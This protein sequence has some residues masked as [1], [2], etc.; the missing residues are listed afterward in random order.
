MT[1]DFDFKALRALKFNA[2]KKQYF[3]NAVLNKAKGGLVLT[4]FD[5][6]AEKKTCA[7]VPFNKYKDAE[8]AFK[9]WKA[10]KDTNLKKSANKVALVKVST[11][12]GEEGTVEVVLDIVKGFK[13]PKKIEAAARPLFDL[14]EKGLKVTGTTEEEEN[15]STADLD[16][17]SIAVQIKEL[18]LGITGIL[19]EELPKAIVPNIKAKKV[20]QKDADITNDL[21]TK[22][23]EL[24]AVY[25]T[26]GSDIQ[27]KIGKHYDSIMNQV[28]K[29]EKVK[30][31]LNNLLGIS[32]GNK[33]V[34]KEDTNDS[35]EVKQ[36]KKLL[37]YATKETDAIWA[38][39][40]KTKDE[41]SKASSQAIKG[42]D[43]LLK[44]LFN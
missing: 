21:F 2:Y 37:A 3:K 17:K 31:A 6:G 18:V 36:L 12:K 43:Q 7:F 26:A 23:D 19:K 14:V 32:E 30:A 4:I 38:S 29:L 44:A 16:S 1:E 35:E 8:N 11:Q 27:Q 28:P 5:I 41:V 10:I 15:E 42:G 24:K 33:D 13:N 39:F 9:A 40:N 34:T 20:S 25:E 22:L